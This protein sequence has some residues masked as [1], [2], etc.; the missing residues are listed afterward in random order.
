MSAVAELAHARPQELTAQAVDAE[1]QA[2]MQQA[3]QP[4]LVP[5]E[6]GGGVYRSEHAAQ[7]WEP[8][9]SMAA[10]EAE[11]ITQGVAT[12]RAIGAAVLP[13]QNY[14]DPS[15]QGELVKQLR[16]DLYQAQMAQI[17]FVEQQNAAARELARIRDEDDED[18]DRE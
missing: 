10:D 13:K 1:F 14:V 4:P 16:P 9:D 3:G 8:A 7:T 18:D 11:L 15:K 6:M 12:I 2:M 5:T 17:A